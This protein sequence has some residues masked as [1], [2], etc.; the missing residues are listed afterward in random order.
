MSSKGR[1]DVTFNYALS[2][3]RIQGNQPHGVTMDLA[4]N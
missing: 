4:S 1:E 3:Q 2:S